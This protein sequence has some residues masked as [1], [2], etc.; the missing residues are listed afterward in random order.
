M[1][2]PGTA[3]LQPNPLRRLHQA[4]MPDY[5]PKATAYWWAVVLLGNAVIAYSLLAIRSLPFGV[6]GQ[7]LGAV[8]KGSSQRH[9]KEMLG[10][11]KSMAEG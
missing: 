3:V 5:N 7:V 4:L 9:V 11:L 2:A 10:K 6:V 1:D 8:A